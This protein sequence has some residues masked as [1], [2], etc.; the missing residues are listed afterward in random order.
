[1]ARPP[2]ALPLDTTLPRWQSVSTHY[3]INSYKR[4]PHK[5]AKAIY[6]SLPF[7]VERYS[8]KKS[9]DTP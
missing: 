7:R 9:V 2:S 3:L 8:S 6:G 1:M 5:R 4:F